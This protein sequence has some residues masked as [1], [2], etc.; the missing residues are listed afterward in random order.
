MVVDSEEDT[1]RLIE[2]RE[3]LREIKVKLPTHVD[4]SE[5]DTK[6]RIP[7]KA[8]CCRAGL[9][10]RIEELGLSSC[11]NLDKGDVIAGMVLT[12]SLME[13]ASVLL[14]L[15]RM[16]VRQVENGVEATLDEMIT[17]LLVGTKVPSPV[18]AVNV[19]TMIDR[20]GIRNLY[21]NLSEAAHPNYDGTGG[22][23]SKF[24]VAVK[25]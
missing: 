17:R 16:I 19:L 4:A 12:R 13:T 21:D 3:R 24:D 9:I 18:Q 14:H 25:T 8:L 20:A 11:D 10:W 23:F 22:A 5:L 15:Q 2:I 6:S 1:A 7:F